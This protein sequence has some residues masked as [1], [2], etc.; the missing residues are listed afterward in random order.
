MDI[1]STV[2]QDDLWAEKDAG[3]NLDYSFN[4]AKIIP[5]GDPISGCTWSVSP[6]DTLV[7]G[8]STNTATS[9]SLT[10]SGGIAR[11]W[12]DVTG[13]WVT[14]AGISD[15]FTL[16]LFIKEPTLSVTALGT[17]LF[18][19]R[20]SATAKMRT[21]RLMLLTRSLLPGVEF[22]NDYIWGK[23]CAAEADLAHQLRVAFTPTAFFPAT[24]TADQITALAGMPW[25]IDP[26][27]DYDPG[28][29]QGN[30]WGLLQLRNRP[31]VSVSEV[32]FAYPGQSGFAYDIPLN[33]IRPDNRY[34]VLNFVPSGSSFMAPL[35]AFSMQA[36]GGGGSIPLAIQI[37]Y[38]AGI[39]NAGQ[40]YPDL[41]DCAYKLASLRICEDAF[42]A[43]S[44]SISI[45]GMSQNSSPPD[46]DKVQA[47][48]DKKIDNLRQQIHGITMMVM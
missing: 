7:V 43:A 2:S 21:E 36:M 30:K 3:A 17:A 18:P 6:L 14:A 38:V 37:T 40:A 4:L 23:L 20:F 5:D 35:N 16:R 42:F 29:F 25:D 28:M 27:Y 48:I 31:L 13:T 47:S 1:T 8:F 33:W 22:K 34:G 45:D 10:L 39:S 26:G 19:N 15:S 32:R 24:P 46:L 44:D 41:I 9:V 11:A 12:Y